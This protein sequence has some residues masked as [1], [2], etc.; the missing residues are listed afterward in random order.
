MMRKRTRL[1]L[2]Y[3]LICTWLSTLLAIA[4]PFKN[5]EIEKIE[6]NDVQIDSLMVMTPSVSPRDSIKDELIKEVE[7]YVY[8]NF[9]KTHKA[10][11]TAIVENGLEK[12]V[13]IMFIMAQTQ[14]ETSFGTA[15]I[16]R[17]NSKRSLFGVISRRYSNYHDAVADYISIL[18]KSYLTNGRTEQHLMQRYTTTKGGRYAEDQNYESKL[19]QTYAYINSKTNIKNLQ[20]KY[21]NLKEED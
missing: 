2:A 17:E 1:N 15:G 20:V 18:K 9:P 14:R 21:K 12:D 13:D 19:R 5:T 6:G 8:R 10:I 4:M 11:P 16:G 3:I 7:N